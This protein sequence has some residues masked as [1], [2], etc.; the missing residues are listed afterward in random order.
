MP[1]YVCQIEDEEPLGP[2]RPILP[3]RE[4]SV[5]VPLTSSPKLRSEDMKLYRDEDGELRLKNLGPDEF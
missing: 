3:P 5:S 1:I 2:R 4:G